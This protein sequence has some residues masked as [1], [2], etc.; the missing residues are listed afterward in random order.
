MGIEASVGL[1]YEK[2]EYVDIIVVLNIRDGRVQV[3]RTTISGLR[4]HPDANQP[5]IPHTCP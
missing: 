4:S 1:P 2:M 5:R 3:T